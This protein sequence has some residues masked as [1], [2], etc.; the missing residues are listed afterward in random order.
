[1]N[2][3]HPVA[4]LEKALDSIP[5]NDKVEFVTAMQVAPCLV[6]RE[7]DPMR[8]LA[9]HDY[10][11][12]L[13]AERLVKYWKLRH[14]FFGDRAYL[15]MTMFSLGG[16]D[17][18]GNGNHGA[19]DVEDICLIWSGFCVIVGSDHQGSPVYVWDPQFWY[20]AK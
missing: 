5:M 1:M 8:F 7:S 10:D 13:A 16:N 18:G 4:L 11:A 6:A 2:L 9:F 17:A 12:Q 14:E 15:S 3:L 20:D 19:L